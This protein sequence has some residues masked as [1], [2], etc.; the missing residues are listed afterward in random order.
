VN[1]E[2]SVKRTV[3]V[4]RVWVLKECR[5]IEDKGKSGSEGKNFDKEALSFY[6]ILYKLMCIIT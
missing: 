4:L 2:W 3:G 5:N 6:H 1:G